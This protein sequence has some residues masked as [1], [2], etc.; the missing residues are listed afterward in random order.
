[1]SRLLL[2][3]LALVALACGSPARTADMSVFVGD[4]AEGGM[5][6]MAVTMLDLECPYR[7]DAGLCCVNAG[8][9]CSDTMPC[10]YPGTLACATDASGHGRCLLG[11]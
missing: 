3:A 2:V 9:A 6:D 1:M 8:G 4:M 7:S 5:T 11:P 10:C